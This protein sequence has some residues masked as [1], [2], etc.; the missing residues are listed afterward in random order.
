MIGGL[1]DHSNQAAKVAAMPLIGPG[2]SELNIGSIL[3][4][5]LKRNNC[6]ASRACEGVTSFRYR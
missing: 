3:K 2:L 4:F 6:C 5:D 1:W